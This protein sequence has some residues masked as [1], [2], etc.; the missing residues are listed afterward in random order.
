MAK[1]KSKTRKRKHAQ[2]RALRRAALQI[3]V[4]RTQSSQAITMKSKKLS[5]KPRPTAARTK[6]TPPPGLPLWASL[7]N[8]WSGVGIFIFILLVSAF[9]VTLQIQSLNLAAAPPSNT[10]AQ[11]SR[12]ANSHQTLESLKAQTAEFI[13]EEAKRNVQLPDSQKLWERLD[14]ISTDL[15]A[16]NT[17][18]AARNI[19]AY[20]AKLAALREK[21]INETSGEAT[22]QPAVAASTPTLANS[23]Q[24][25]AVPILIYHHTPPDFET[26]LNTLTA[27]GYTTIT[28]DNL[29]DHLRFGRP[30]P[31][32]SVVL[33]FDDGFSSQMQA[34]EI[35]KRH[36][37]K[38]TFYIIT[39]GQ[40]SSWCIGAARRY[41]QT[42]GC[43]DAYMNWDEVTELDRSGLIEIAA[44]SVDHLALATQPEQMQQFQI[45]E[46]KKVLE[47]KLGHPI[48]HFAYPYGSFS[49]TTV[50]LIKA[51]G[52]LTAV[53]TKTGSSHNLDS[54]YTLTRERN[55]YKLP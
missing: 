26:Q 31:N 32:K 50:E 39:S 1:P 2:R 28:M 4:K 5:S 52:Y 6:T 33:S 44:H 29:S 54:I 37:M 40:A 38:A 43:G 24:A 3:E 30:L 10:P 45:Q 36:D 47:D 34:F 46:S 41:D 51:S 8:N 9:G 53:T 35:L 22:T 7:K 19:K 16:D 23:S 55:V 20:R 17:Q 15:A 13:A 12:L 25:T 27:K 48:N 49:P 18:A 21:L 42:P 11:P 14:K